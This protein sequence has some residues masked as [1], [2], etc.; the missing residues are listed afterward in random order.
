MKQTSVP[1]FVK[2]IGGKSQLLKQFKPFFLE[3]R[4]G[5]LRR[6]LPNIPT[7]H[8]LRLYFD[9]DGEK[10]WA[11]NVAPPEN[12]VSAC[13]I[14]EEGEA[15]ELRDGQSQYLQQNFGKLI[16]VDTIKTSV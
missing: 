14:D 12:V 9:P 3:K 11:I 2:W 10:Y 6:L 7:E 8:E 4:M 13:A 1:T 16:L 5:K 15:P